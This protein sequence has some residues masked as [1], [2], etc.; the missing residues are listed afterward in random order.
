MRSLT[1]LFASELALVNN[2]LE[3]IIPEQAPLADLDEMALACRY[4]L[5][6]PGKRFRAL[7]SLLTARTLGHELNLVMPY[8]A[9]VE[10]IHAYS[11]IHDDLPCMDDDDFRRG[12]PTHHKVFG[13]AMAVI[14]GDALQALAFEV[15][16]DN[17][18]QM[19]K[20]A[21][22]ALGLVAKAS[23]Y[24]GMVGGQAI[25]LRAGEGK[26]SLD[27]EKV[28]TLHHLKTGRLIQAATAGAAILCEAGEQA[29]QSFADFG[30]DLGLAFQVADDLLDHDENHP[31]VMGLPK[32]MGVEAT[33]AL[34][35]RLTESC[36]Y[37]LEA[38]GE[39]AKD[40]RF[41][42]EFNLQRTE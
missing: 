9:A 11:L 7:L 38:F 14:S 15:I 35:S 29:V 3:K 6:L 23:G 27:A 13:E 24:Q 37:Q 18:Q 25:D 22:R 32:Y 20:L 36:L 30:T 42:V 26:L 2:Y 21:L 1:D 5:L 31:E 16:A 12:Q 34:L 8:A 33:Q 10:L 17:Y 40:L 4:S 39:T 19:P 28:K 41:I